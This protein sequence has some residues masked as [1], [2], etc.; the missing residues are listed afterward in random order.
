MP[1]ST[2]STILKNRDAIFQRFLDGDLC[3]KRKRDAEFPDVEAALNTWFKQCRDKEVPLSLYT[4]TMHIRIRDIL[5]YIHNFFH[6]R[7]VK[8]SLTPLRF[9]LARLYC[10]MHD[11]YNM[12][13]KFYD[14]YIGCVGVN[15]LK[16]S[17]NM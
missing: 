1:A 16:K 12:R 11:P 17:E 14:P 9:D 13:K 3:R 10:I 7:K 4:N 5:I 6:V 2:F 8:L 15:L